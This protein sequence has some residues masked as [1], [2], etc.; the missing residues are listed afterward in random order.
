MQSTDGQAVYALQAVSQWAFKAEGGLQTKT[1]HLTEHSIQVAAAD[2]TAVD[3][4]RLLH[5]DFA[6]AVQASSRGNGSRG[7]VKEV[8]SGC[9]MCRSC[10]RG[11]PV[12]G[13]RCAVD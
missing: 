7:A 12:K 13:E 2:F 3:T 6:T 9:S 10:A 11:G 4:G 1:A 5:T 8:Q